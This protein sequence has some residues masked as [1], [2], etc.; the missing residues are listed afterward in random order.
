MCR[1]ASHG[2]CAK[3]PVSAAIFRV[4]STVDDGLRQFPP[5][6]ERPYFVIYNLN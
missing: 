6:A 5:T 2:T 3:F 1:H 4:I